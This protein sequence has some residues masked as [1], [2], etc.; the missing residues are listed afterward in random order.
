MKRQA[1]T[2]NHRISRCVF[3][4]TET[5]RLAVA[6]LRSWC[7]AGMGATVG[8]KCL[9]G[10]GVRIDR[11]WTTALGMRCVLEPHVWLNV[12]GDDA[13]VEIGDY[14]FV[15]R[16]TEI[17]VRERVTIGN[18]VLIAPGVFI[19]DHGHNTDLDGL[20]ATQG[21][22]SAPVVIEEGV[23]V[24]AKAVLLPGVQI[25]QGAVVGAGAVVTK[26]VP[27]ETVVAGVPARPLHT[28]R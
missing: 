10:S 12:V 20:I 2:R 1:E 14:S 9:F 13:R 5:R 8:A 4:L 25:G 27:A 24:G 3:R 21:C 28:R 11:P 22:S 6:R 23:W 18:H 7:F 19:T 16:G 17:G 26:N 15:G